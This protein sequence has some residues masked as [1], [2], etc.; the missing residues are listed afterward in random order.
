MTPSHDLIRL[1]Q[2]YG[3]IPAEIPAHY[4]EWAIYQHK[5]KKVK[6]KAVKPDIAWDTP[7]N[8]PF[9]KGNNNG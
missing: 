3:K 6:T 2:Q 5:A 9:N 1:S 8:A 4:V 7:T